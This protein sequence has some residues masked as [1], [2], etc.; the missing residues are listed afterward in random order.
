[1]AAHPPEKVEGQER[2]LT[3]FGVLVEVPAT[4]PQQEKEIK[5][6]ETGKEGIQVFL[7]VG[8][9]PA[10]G[11]IPSGSGRRSECRQDRRLIGRGPPCA[12]LSA[13]HKAHPFMLLSFQN[14]LQR[15]IQNKFPTTLRAP[16]PS[17]VDA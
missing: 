3:S 13:L 9:V 17:R 10:A 16:W 1:M 12:G 11:R 2:V 7:P 14:H 8:G 6:T 5:G 15:N 4:T